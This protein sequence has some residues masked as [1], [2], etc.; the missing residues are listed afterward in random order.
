MLL[1]IITF[2]IYVLDGYLELKCERRCFSN[3]KCS[4]NLPRFFS[5]SIFIT[6]N[7]RKQTT[8]NS[9]IANWTQHMLEGDLNYN[10]SW[11]SV[12]HS[13]PLKSDFKV[14]YNI[15]LTSL[16]FVFRPH[17]IT[18]YYSVCFYVASS[19]WVKDNWH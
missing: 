18:V 9:S 1:L 15:L 3:K 6:N 16:F 8:D 12:V 10:S 14:V 17:T 11:I 19:V 5:M 2:S 13:W 4:G 7:N